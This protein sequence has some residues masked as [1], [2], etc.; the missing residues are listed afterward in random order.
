M[1]IRTVRMTFQEDKVEEFLRYFDTHKQQIRDFS[2]CHHLAL[3]Q[4]MHQ[5]NILTTYSIWESEQAL[6]QYRDSEIFK[7][8]WKATKRLFSEKPEAFSQKKLEEV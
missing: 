5:K 1:L 2:G 8:V 7:S 4:D 6:N 3:W